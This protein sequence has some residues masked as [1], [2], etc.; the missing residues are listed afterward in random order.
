MA[1][2]LGAGRRTHTGALVQSPQLLLDGRR[3]CLIGK[4]AAAT[5]RPATRAQR[6]CFFSPQ[7]APAA[8]HKSSSWE[9]AGGGVR[10]G[11]ASR[12]EHC[13][14]SLGQLYKSAAYAPPDLVAAPLK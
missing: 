14:L 10:R 5:D 4:S 11:R 13:F 12:L 9:V 1:G 2:H 7:T 3:A 8:A 6:N